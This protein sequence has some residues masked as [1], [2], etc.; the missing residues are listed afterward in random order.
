[1]RVKRYVRKAAG[2]RRMTKYADGG[3]KTPVSE[4]Q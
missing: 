1:M 3:I 2:D 4:I